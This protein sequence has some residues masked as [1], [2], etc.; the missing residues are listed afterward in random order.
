LIPARL[1]IR[2][3]ESF[4]DF[5]VARKE[6]QIMENGLLPVWTKGFVP[7]GFLV[8]PFSLEAADCEVRTKTKVSCYGMHAFRVALGVPNQEIAVRSGDDNL[9]LPPERCYCKPVQDLSFSIRLE[10]LREPEI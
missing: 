6:K 7:A 5:R 4:R 1:P 10:L 3:F 8:Q 9:S 2:L